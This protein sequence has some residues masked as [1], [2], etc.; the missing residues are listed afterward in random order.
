MQSRSQRH[1]YICYVPSRIRV[2]DFH[3]SSNSIFRRA[4]IG[5]PNNYRT[6]EISFGI[7]HL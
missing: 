6:H 4:R 3:E 2:A 1:I 5:T 7:H